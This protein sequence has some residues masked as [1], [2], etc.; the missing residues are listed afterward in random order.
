MSCTHR[1]RQIDTAHLRGV[2]EREARGFLAK[3]DRVAGRIAHGP[4]SLFR[5]LINSSNLD[6]MKQ[7]PDSF[8]QSKPHPNVL[9]GC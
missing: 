2:D 6:N 5:H 9:S 4:I 8:I 1:G 3:V 7:R